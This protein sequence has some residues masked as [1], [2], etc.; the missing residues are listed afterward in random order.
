M[1]HI[2]SNIAC[3]LYNDNEF[4]QVLE[5]NYKKGLVRVKVLSTGKVFEIAVRKED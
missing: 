3:S 5:V 4:Y 1:N 2:I